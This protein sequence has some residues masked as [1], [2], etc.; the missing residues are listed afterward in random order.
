VCDAHVP[1]IPF[2]IGLRV[3]SK[4][5]LPFL[6]EHEYLGETFRNRHI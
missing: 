1:S 4:L 6:S 3:I 2:L 5:I